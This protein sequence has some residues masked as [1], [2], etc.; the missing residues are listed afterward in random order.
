MLNMDQMV[1]KMIDN[2][3]M[4]M[5]MDILKDEPKVQKEAAVQ[6][7][8]EETTIEEV[9]MEC[10]EEWRD[11]EDYE[12]LYQVS[13]FGR[14]KS[15]RRNQIIQLRKAPSGKTLGL[16]LHKN[17]KKKWHT[18]QFLVL[19]T[20]VGI[21]NDKY[22]TMLHLDGDYNNNRLD[23]LMYADELNDIPVYCITTK[24][25]YKSATIAKEIDGYNHKA[26]ARS[27][28]T[29]YEHAGRLADG[30]KCMWTFIP[31]K[32]F[33]KYAKGRNVITNK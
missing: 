13:N 20:F 24:K 12:N 5:L 7:V 28:N 26:I 9:P 25:A 22:Y 1:E 8:Q 6:E 10:E 27:C 30:T 16:Y 19:K 15:L 23:N 29:K 3:L 14:V 33:D 32:L 18:I 31:K 2:M 11:I 4:D 17:G 21:P